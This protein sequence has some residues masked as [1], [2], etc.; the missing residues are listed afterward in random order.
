M[1]TPER[2][3]ATPLSRT[4]LFLIAFLASFLILRAA[5]ETLTQQ[6][7]VY[8][9][10][11]ALMLWAYMILVLFVVVYAWRMNRAYKISRAGARAGLVEARGPWLRGNRKPGQTNEAT[12]LW[13][14]S[15]LVKSRRARWQTLLVVTLGYGVGMLAYWYRAKISAAVDIP[16]TSGQVLYVALLF[17]GV[18]MGFFVVRN[19]SKDQKDFITSLTAVFGGAF[20]A[21]FLGGLKPEQVDMLTALA[22]YAVGFTASGAINLFVYNKL[23]REYSTTGSLAAR[24]AID[25]LY[26]SDK[27]KVIDA[28]FQKSFEEDPNFA[29]RLL[30]QALAQFRVRVLREFARKIASKWQGILAP[31]RATSLYLLTSIRCRVGE[32]HDGGPA[33]SDSS[34]PSSPLS[35]PLSSPP[36]NP[37]TDTGP[38]EVR[39]KKLYPEEITEA[40]FRMGITVKSSDNLVYIVTPGE[41]RKPF[42]L[43]ESVAGL[44][45]R[46]RQTIV[47]DRDKRK[48]FRHEEFK[49]GRCPADLEG[50]RGLDEIDYVSYVSIPVVSRI[51]NPEEVPLGIINVDTKLL[52]ASEEEVKALPRYEQSAD[53]TIRAEVAQSTLNEWG[54]RLYDAEDEAVKY[55]EDMR[56][57]AVPIMELYLKCTQGTLA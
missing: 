43:Y 30:V 2:A 41:Y 34:P 54:A 9:N 8:T 22:N 37:P 12:L 52:A 15:D 16:R 47:M 44:A 49:N 29:R 27:A 53:G 13:R 24:A 17:L 23:V 6:G 57:V 50:D 51:G 45:L 7:L 19:W 28:Y 25:N 42:P 21:S 4:I 11:L 38:Y 35:S 3:T 10:P 1:S 40:M 36:D 39:F 26:G 31:S 48:K 55:L 20:I 46:V 33:Q 56:A 14:L 5:P 18:I 32:G